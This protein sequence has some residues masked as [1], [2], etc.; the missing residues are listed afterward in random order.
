MVNR[1]RE[2]P[3]LAVCAWLVSVCSDLLYRHD[4]YREYRRGALTLRG[5]LVA[6]QNVTGSLGLGQPWQ[7]GD[8][9]PTGLR[10]SGDRRE[11]NC[12]RYIGYDIAHRSGA[13]RAVCYV[14]GGQPVRISSMDHLVAYTF[15]ARNLLTRVI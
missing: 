2:W 14:L 5:W 13:L 15:Y 3:R 12:V 8:D 9:R 4:V 6:L 7:A 1:S 10:I 11:Y